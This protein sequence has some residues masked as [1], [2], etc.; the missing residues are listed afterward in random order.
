MGA[1]CSM[2]RA[3][4]YFNIHI[5]VPLEPHAHY[6]RYVFHDLIEFPVSN[7]NTF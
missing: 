2:W 6:F 3:Q 1:I 7:K 5:F 4:E